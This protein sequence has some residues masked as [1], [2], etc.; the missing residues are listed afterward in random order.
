MSIKKIFIVIG[1]RPDAIKSLMLYQLLKND[2]GFDV[3][4]CN[5]GQHTD[6]M[7]QVL[8]IFDVKADAN[9][10]A[11]QHNENLDQLTAYLLENIGREIHS[12]NPD[13]V[14]VQGDT[15]SSFSGA[16]SA[17][18]AKVPIAHV[19]AGLRTYNKYGPFP[20]EMYRKMIDA[21]SDYLFAPTESAA[22]NLIMEGVSKDKIHVVGNT[23]IDAL[24]FIKKKLNDV[25]LVGGNALF[26]KVLDFKE[27]KKL[28]LLTLHRRELL[29]E[30]IEQICQDIKEVVIQNPE[31]RM[32]FPMHKNPVLRETLQ[33]VF[34]TSDQVLLI[35]ALPYGEFVWLMLQ[36]D[37]IITDSGGIQEEAPSLG[38]RVIVLRKE[39]ERNEALEEGSK[40]VGWDKEEIENAINDSLSKGPI[41][42]SLIFGNGTASRQILEV[43][44]DQFC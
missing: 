43:L 34:G 28:L 29:Q 7:D 31:L 21:A 30:S 14:I 42:P 1:T 18:H 44:K 5:T 26:S 20:E 8:N 17:Y 41:P 24:F 37:L 23:G 19:E 25:S 10:K 36:S 2:S 27:S 16:L 11:H 6:M 15:I 38:K 35:D 40:L 3:F 39:T 9:L 13:L 33:K 12:F 32:V 4:L 22:Q